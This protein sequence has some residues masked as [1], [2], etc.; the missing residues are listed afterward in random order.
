M[1]SVFSQT[2]LALMSVL[3][4]QRDGKL[5]D[6]STLAR[7]A[8]KPQTVSDALY[9]AQKDIVLGLMAGGAG[10]FMDPFAGECC[11]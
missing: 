1:I 7:Y 5:S 10:L 9:L 8:I 11:D 2:L 4:T 6:S 3:P